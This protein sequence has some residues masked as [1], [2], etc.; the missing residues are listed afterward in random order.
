MK[1]PGT[2]EAIRAALRAAVEV[3]LGGDWQGAHEVAQKHED[4]ETACW[5][6]AV[7]HRIEGD[8][9]NARY[10][11]RRCGRR[12]REDVTTDDELREIR[13]ALGGRGPG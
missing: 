2:K 6:H 11:Y 13:T 8:E 10:W 5:L 7:V 1:D 9:G 4:D 3:A 12:L